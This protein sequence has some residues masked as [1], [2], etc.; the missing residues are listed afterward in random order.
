MISYCNPGNIFNNL[1]DLRILNTLNNK[2]K[3]LAEPTLFIS[4]KFNIKSI[5]EDNEIPKSIL[6]IKK[7]LFTYSKYHQNSF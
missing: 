4:M 2:I 7:Y 6:K 5:N 3:F 1:T